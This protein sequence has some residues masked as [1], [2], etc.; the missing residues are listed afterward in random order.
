M[1]VLGKISAIMKFQ[2]R[3]SLFFPIYL[4]DWMKKVPKYHSPL[5]RNPQDWH[6]HTALTQK[7]FTCLGNQHENNYG[8]L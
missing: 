3:A 4:T 8:E 6:S 5:F 7:A 1:E 2:I